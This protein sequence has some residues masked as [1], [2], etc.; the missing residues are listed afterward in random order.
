[1]NKLGNKIVIYT[2]PHLATDSVHLTIFIRGQTNILHCVR[3]TFAHELLHSHCV[4]TVNETIQTNYSYFLREQK[5]KVY[6]NYLI[7]LL[8]FCC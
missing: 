8:E 6:S 5:L 1:M 2:N 7:V 4:P 3:K